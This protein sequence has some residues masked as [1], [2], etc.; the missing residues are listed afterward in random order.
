MHVHVSAGVCVGA[1]GGGF[2]CVF[3][4]KK[5]ICLSFQSG[6]VCMCMWIKVNT[7]YQCVTLN[8]LTCLF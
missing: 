2:V 3:V 1:W 7:N 5:H 4:E 8:L 6:C